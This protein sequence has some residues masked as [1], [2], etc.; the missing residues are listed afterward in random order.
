MCYGYY[1]TN[2][3]TKYSKLKFECDDRIDLTIKYSNCEVSNIGIPKNKEKLPKGTK[4]LK[5][6]QSESKISRQRDKRNKQI[7]RQKRKLNTVKQ[8]MSQ[9]FLYSEI[10]FFLC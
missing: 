3:L 2:P 7:N 5:N 9:N 4:Q 8:K 10:F 1:Y 6:K